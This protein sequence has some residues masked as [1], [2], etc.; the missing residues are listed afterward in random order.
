MSTPLNPDALEAAARAANEEGWTCFEGS[1]EPGDYDN[2]EDCQRVDKKTA[3]AIVTA[4]LAAAQ[5][6]VNSVEELDAL[7]EGTILRDSYG[8]ALNKRT[9]NWWVTNGENNLPSEDLA[10]EIAGTAHTY[11]VL[12]RPVVKP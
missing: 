1:G 9:A 6:V 4:Y 2:C 3:T 10:D 11:T 5:P 12:Y 7:P 8:L